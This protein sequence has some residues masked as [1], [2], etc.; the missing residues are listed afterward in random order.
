MARCSKNA[1]NVKKVYI[2]RAQRWLERNSALGEPLSGKSPG[3][4]FKRKQVR[5]SGG[6][7]RRNVDSEK[8]R[9]SVN[10]YTGLHSSS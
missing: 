1:E 6:K 4:K 5:G 9:A 8:I 7:G 3:L 2:N 10:N